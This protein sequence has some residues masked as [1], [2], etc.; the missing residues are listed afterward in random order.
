MPQEFKNL[1]TPL[2]VGRLTIPNRMF[3]SAHIHRFHP[4]TSPPNER[5]VRYYEARA[6][7]GIGLIIA[8]GNYLRGASTYSPP[9]AYESD[10]VI[11]AWKAQV[12]AVHQYGTK[13]FCQLDHAGG[14]ADSRPGGGS[15][16][17]ASAVPRR[18][19]CFPPRSEVPHEIDIDE[20]SR[21]LEVFGQAARRV[22][23]AGCDGI[24][25][26][27]IW[28]KLPAS[29]VSPLLNRRTDAYG[30]SLQNRMR[31][32]LEVIDAV[33]E[34]VGSDLAVGVTFTADEF[35]D[36][37]LTMDDSLEIARIL[38]ATGKV[39]Y[40]FPCAGS[41]TP[42]HVPPMYYP[43]AS[44]V[45]MAAA[46][47][48]V[49]NIPVFTGGRINDPVLAERILADNQADMISMTR[50]T[51]CDPEIPNKAREGRLDEIRRCIGCNEGCA[52]KSNLVIPI[53]CSLN[54]EA[55]REKVFDITPIDSPK[56][57]MV[58]GG[59]AAGLETARV[60]ASRGHKVSLYE[61][62]DVL[63]K[64]LSFAAKF[65][66]REDFEEVIRYYNYQM[67]LL[68]VDVHLG[69]TVTPEMVI[70]ENPDAVVVATG[71]VPY[72]PDIPGANGENVVEL[73]QVVQD[74]VAIGQKVVVADCQSHIYG[75]DAA[76]ALAE[77]GKNVELLT[78]FVYAGGQVDTYTIPATYTRVLSKGVIV[79]PL[80]EVKAIK[81]NTVITQN[82][83]TG[84]Q[85]EIEGVDT[86]VFCTSGA[87]NDDLY[88]S[89][90]G[91]V[92]ELYQAG[93]CVSPRKLID[94]IYDGA[95]VGRKI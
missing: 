55:G 50:A 47:K 64:E 33:R 34:N 32:L 10:A 76:D 69:V 57:V 80:T 40:L 91:K 31:F 17:S 83:L 67:K 84:S 41:P 21:V 79:T 16:V 26:A 14:S 12:D 4:A 81:G 62:E 15:V 73:R 56:R 77:R 46:I 87:V 82:V 86:I 11:P 66:G 28:G 54:P 9:S 6:K 27:A 95:I 90:K 22:K 48:E 5:A 53:T 89:L 49:V 60:A 44:F 13:I 65:P 35:M 39:D 70:K 36:G 2:K 94:S 23:E 1:F 92:K 61:K 25:I 8:G 30:G 29:F 78:E 88:R 71:S 75:L 59:G 51:I 85:R 18:E 68:G 58:I 37:G 24:E 43:L 74:N 19:P 45:Y 38:E 52:G 20:I 72:I 42:A 3:M 63:A 7:G 93:Q